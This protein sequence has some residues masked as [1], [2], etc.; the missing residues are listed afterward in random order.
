MAAARSARVVGTAALAVREALG[1]RSEAEVQEGRALRSEAV[2]PVARSEA[3]VR[4]AWS[5]L[6]V[7]SAVVLEMRVALV[8][9]VLG[10]WKASVVRSAEAREGWDVLGVARAVRSASLEVLVALSAGR[11]R[12]ALRSAGA[13]VLRSVRSVV[14]EA[15]SA[16]DVRVVARSAAVVQEGRALR[17]AARSARDVR[18]GRSAVLRSVRAPLLPGVAGAGRSAEPPL[19]LKCVRSLNG[20]VRGV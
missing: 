20:C 7:W 6:V 5:V 1:G 15:R 19:W 18:V 12:S 8:L 17:S 11:E 3:R 9:E 14:Q 16:R 4:V 13:Q 10:G 2:L